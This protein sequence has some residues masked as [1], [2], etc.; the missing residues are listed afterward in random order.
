MSTRAEHQKSELIDRVADLA[1]KRPGRERAA[2]TA[3]FLPSSY[4][5]M[6]HDD[7]IRGSAEDLFG[8][9]L[10]LWNFGAQ[11][12]ADSFKVR[13]YNPSVEEHGW[14]SSHTIVEIV[15][16]D[17]P[18]LVD[19]VTAALN[20]LD[21]TVYLVIHPILKVA[22][23]EQGRMVTC[24]GDSAAPAE[25]FIQVRVNEQGSAERLDEIRRTIETVLTDVRAAV[26]DWRAMRARIAETIEEIDRCPPELPAE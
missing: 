10:S 4:A 1:E 13:A 8:A 18:F 20:G 24:A 21:L 7:K 17:M 25:S 15:N 6:P 5:N 26:R 14:R 19:S 16:D 3:C 9:A 2:Q 22:R 23:D 12:R 11:R